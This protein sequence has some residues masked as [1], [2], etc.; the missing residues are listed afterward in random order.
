MV[1]QVLALGA[2]LACLVC[3]AAC[4]N[5][6][7]KGDQTEQTEQ[8]GQTE[9]IER[10]ENTAALAYIPIDDRPV[11]TDRV[12]YLAESLDYELEMPDPDL[13][14][15]HLDN[16]KLNSNGTQYGD[17]AQLLQWLESVEADCYVLSLDQLLSGGL[18]NSRIM[19]EDDL[20]N[21]YAA[22]DSVL[23]A[24]GEK[25][26]VIFDTVMRLASTVGYRGFGSAE[27]EGLRTYGAVARASLEG[28]A[29]TVDNIIAGYLYSA[30]G[31]TISAS[32][33]DEIIEEYL[34]ARERKLRLSDYFLNAVAEKS[35]IYVYYG[36]DDSSAKVTVQTNEINYITQKL[37]NGTVFSGCDELGLMG[38]TKLYLETLQQGIK[39]D[40]T[41]F[42]GGEE[43]AAD[44]YDTG[45]LKDTVEGH[46]FSLGVTA[47]EDAELKII[48]LTQPATSTTKAYNGYCDEAAE[49]IAQEIEAE[50]PVIVIDASTSAWY[51]R[52]QFKLASSVPLGLLLGYSNWN[53]GANTVGCALANG[54]ARYGYLKYGETTE[55]GHDAFLKTLAFSYVKDIA[56][57]I[58]SAVEVTKYISSNYSDVNNF[59][60]EIVDEDALNAEFT[61]IMLSNDGTCGATGLL[62]AL[63]ESSYITDLQNYTLSSHKT[64]SADNFYFPWYRTFEASFTVT[65]S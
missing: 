59:Y 10:Y 58:T 37:K 54:L 50:D 42:G 13:Y 45:T 23:A 64:V 44:D 11:N 47:S 25:P 29:L 28:E 53:T 31:G 26:T 14:K 35:N 7:S 36:V 41:Y 1:K 39:A 4:G 55:S 3:M 22:I 30:D 21:S 40:V 17:T 24:V 65:L 38:V 20:T 5:E 48:V 19:T 16:Q 27:Y 60:S 34:A 61:Q 43:L 52:L 62:K 32:V 33:S 51:G 12:I 9:Q 49:A 8:T 63:N 46:L 18:V 15:T 2:A 56:Y 6:T 57:K